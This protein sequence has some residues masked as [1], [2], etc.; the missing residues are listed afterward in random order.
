MQKAAS[1]IQDFSDFVFTGCLLKL[2]FPNQT[3]LEPFDNH[4]LFSQILTKTR[5]LGKNENRVSY[6]VHQRFPEGDLAVPGVLEAVNPET[7]EHH[8]LSRHCRG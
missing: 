1:Q 3:S 7:V 2:S 4:F 5:L 8:G 6:Y